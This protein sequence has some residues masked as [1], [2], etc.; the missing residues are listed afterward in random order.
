[1]AT[2]LDNASRKRLDRVEKSPFYGPK[3]RRLTKG[4]QGVIRELIRQNRGIE[5]RQMII[6]RDADRRAARRVKDQA[7]RYAQKTYNERRDQWR[8]VRDLQHEQGTDA[9]FWTLYE[10]LKTAGMLA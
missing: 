8:K 5:A 2:P 10:E 9:E 6:E 1:M 4:E 7:K 3:L